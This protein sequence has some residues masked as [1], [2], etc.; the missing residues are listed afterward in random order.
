MVAP[1][2]L[3]RFPHLSWLRRDRFFCAALL[4]LA[5]AAWPV[6]AHAQF[7]FREPPNRQ[8]PAALEERE[9]LFVWRQFLVN[10]AVG[11]FTID[12]RLVYR[13]AR[14]PSTSFGFSFRGDWY[15]GNE[16][17][18]LTLTHP[19]GSVTRARVVVIDGAPFREDESGA[20]VAVD[21]DQLAAPL[22]DGLPFTW[23]DLLM[24][25]LA[26]GDPAYDGPERYLGRP[27]H[28]Y[29]L[30]NPDA[31]NFP[32]RVVVT[33]D[34]DYAALL[35]AALHDSDGA[36]VKRIRVGGFK[37]YAGGWMFSSLHWEHRPSRAS[38]RLDVDAFG[39][40]R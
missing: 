2:H 21:A 13:P 15:T 3:T 7:K 6:A 32:A 37:Q 29:A 20:L 18:A 9:W 30:T 39:A 38:V 4:A 40:A 34:E 35:V 36:L 1:L 28:R 23:D 24:P 25:F 16:S 10:R 27:A 22:V 26:W 5:C 19:D 12:G 8:D 31:V 11:S 14:Q 33:L 17:S